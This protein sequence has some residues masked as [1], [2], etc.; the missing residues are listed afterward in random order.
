MKNGQIWGVQGK[1]WVLILRLQ[2]TSSEVGSLPSWKWQ[3]Q[4]QRAPINSPL[5]CFGPSTSFIPKPF[6]L[7]FQSVLFLTSTS[8]VL[9]LVWLIFHYY[10]LKTP[11]IIRSRLFSLSKD[12]RCQSLPM[13]WSIDLYRQLG[14]SVQL[15]S[16]RVSDNKQTS[17]GRWLTHTTPGSEFSDLVWKRSL[18][19]TYLWPQRVFGYPDP[20]QAFWL[21]WSWLHHSQFS[22]TESQFASVRASFHSL[23]ATLHPSWVHTTCL[24]STVN[25]HICWAFISIFNYASALQ[26]WWPVWHLYPRRGGFP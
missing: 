15:D 10:P 23:S 2:S 22:D 1:D 4:L 12:F 9:P 17:S 3:E 26:T 11:C 25:N 18:I 6:F 20:L 5:N 8:L 19:L 13:H 16:S 21:A 7:F 24:Q 14:W